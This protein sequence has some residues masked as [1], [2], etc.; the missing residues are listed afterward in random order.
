MIKY[1][2]LLWIQLKNNKENSYDNNIL[3]VVAVHNI[4]KFWV[5]VINTFSTYFLKIKNY[6]KQIQISQEIKKV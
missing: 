3:Q 4:I 5:E 1:V 6:V 2:H